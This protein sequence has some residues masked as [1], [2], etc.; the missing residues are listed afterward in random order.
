MAK[1][2][3]MFLALLTFAFLSGMIMGCGGGV[4]E[5][6]MQELMNLKQ[7]VENLKKEVSDKENQKSDI[8]KQI[9]KTEADIAAKQKLIDAIKNCK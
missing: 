6:Q 7:Q 8:Q 1:F 4:S 9:S 5:E 3:N 2:K